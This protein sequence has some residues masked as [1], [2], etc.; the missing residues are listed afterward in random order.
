MVA[1]LVYH[2]FVRIQ[3]SIVWTFRDI[4][5][6]LEH[7]IRKSVEAVETAA[8]RLPILQPGSDLRQHWDSVKQSV[9]NYVRHGGSDLIQ[10]DVQYV[11]VANKIQTE[12]RCK[13]SSRIFTIVSYLQNMQALVGNTSHGCMVP[14]D[15]VQKYLK[16]ISNLDRRCMSEDYWPSMDSLEKL[17]RDSLSRELSVAE[18][19][20]IHMTFTWQSENFFTHFKP[21]ELVGSVSR[22]SRGF[23]CQSSL[24]PRPSSSEECTSLLREALV[25]FVDFMLY[26]PWRM[27]WLNFVLGC[28]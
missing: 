12:I 19:E 18:I 11:G 27:Q 14:S 10:L 4:L 26:I 5:P 21:D 25:I 15:A 2:M 8:A 6:S 7:D 20:K 28:A 9:L 17:M 3:L 23:V 1:Y 13:T 22:P 16:T 24:L